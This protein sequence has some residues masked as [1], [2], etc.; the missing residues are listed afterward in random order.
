MGKKG[1]LGRE[2][3]DSVQD[4]QVCRRLNAPEESAENLINE[5][6]LQAKLAMSADHPP[7]GVLAVTTPKKGLA[8]LRS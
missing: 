7:K 3:F 6:F 8:C 2:L 5:S 1:H 4:G